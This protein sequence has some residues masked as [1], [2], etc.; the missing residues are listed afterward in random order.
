MPSIV[1][2]KQL[3]MVETNAIHYYLTP[4]KQNIL[5]VRMKGY[6]LSHKLWKSRLIV[7]LNG[8]NVNNPR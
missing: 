6:R 2:K 8:L 7:I 1:L 4:M 5:N 3:V